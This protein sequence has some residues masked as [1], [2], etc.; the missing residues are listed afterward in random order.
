MLYELQNI[1]LYKTEKT[2]SFLTSKRWNKGLFFIP[3]PRTR[4][5]EGRSDETDYKYPAIYARWGKANLKYLWTDWL[6]VFGLCIDIASVSN[7]EHLINALI[8]QPFGIDRDQRNISPR[9]DSPTLHWVW[10]V[11]AAL[12]KREVN[13]VIICIVVVIN[14]WN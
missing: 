2:Q 8:S 7:K 9:H 4:R 11:L 1:M 6:N 13:L 3:L 14:V 12:E 5:S 10:H